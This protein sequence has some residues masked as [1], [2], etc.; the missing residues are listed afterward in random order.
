MSQQGPHSFADIAYAYRLYILDDL[1]AEPQEIVY[2]YMRNRVYISQRY[3]QGSSVAPIELS[4]EITVMDVNTTQIIST[5]DT[6]PYN[7]PHCLELDESGTFLTANVEHGGSICIDP[8]SGL[9][10]D[11]SYTAGTGSGQ[12]S[13]YYS[14]PASS[15]STQSHRAGTSRGGRLLTSGPSSRSGTEDFIAEIDLRSGKMRRQV[16]VPRNDSALLDGRHV[17]FSAPAIRFA[18]RSSSSGMP[19]VHVQG[20]MVVEAIKAVYGAKRIYA[21]SR[22]IMLV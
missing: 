9:V 18:G 19:V 6:S 21:T 15:S 20:D 5:I 14:S 4:H 17:A 7:G 11:A 10:Y 1:L 22:S 12:Q 8:D 13:A 16:N 3:R 2:D